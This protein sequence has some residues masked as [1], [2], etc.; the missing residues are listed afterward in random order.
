MAFLEYRDPYNQHVLRGSS[1]GSG[2][3]VIT[4]E[5]SPV[6]CEALKPGQL[7][8]APDLVSSCLSCHLVRQKEKHGTQ[9]VWTA[10]QGCSCKGSHQGGVFV[11]RPLYRLVLLCV[12]FGSFVSLKVQLSLEKP[13]GGCCLNI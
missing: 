10:A 2:D 6:G 5:T 4:R 8:Y 12:A 1:E 13:P 11:L 3:E 9:A 7:L